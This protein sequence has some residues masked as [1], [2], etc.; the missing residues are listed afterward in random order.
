MIALTNYKELVRVK[1]FNVNGTEYT[2]GEKVSV[3]EAGVVQGEIEDVT[4]TTYG[5]LFTIK[6]E[7]ST[8]Q[9][10]EDRVGKVYNKCTFCGREDNVPTKNVGGYEILE[11][12][13]DCERE[14]NSVELTFTF[15]GSQT[16]TINGEETKIIGVAVDED[17]DSYLLCNDEDKGMFIIDDDDSKNYLHEALKEDEYNK[18][19]KTYEEFL[20]EGYP[21]LQVII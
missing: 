14:I 17:Y 21:Q 1:T 16:H 7:D 2:K 4:E 11:H 9:T 19:V 12:C 13:S 5:H 10:T 6:T 3:W 18:L 8:F 20:Q 15:E